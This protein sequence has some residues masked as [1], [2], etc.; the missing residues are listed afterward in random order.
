MHRIDGPGATVDNRFTDGD[1]IGGVQ[2]T[3]VTD[4][5]ANDVQENICKVIEDAGV[6]LSKGNFSQLKTAIAAMIAA[7]S[8]DLLNTVRTGVASAATVNLTTAAPNSR[9]INITGSNSISGFTIAAGKC[10]FVRFDAVLTLTNSASLVT[11]SGA[12]IVTAA[13]DTCIIRATAANVVEILCYTPGIPQ[14]IGYRQTQQNVLASRA[15]NTTYTN[16]TGRTIWVLASINVAS[17]AAPLLVLDGVSSASI[18]NNGS[19]AN[20]ILFSFPVKDGQTYRINGGTSA[21]YWS[22]MR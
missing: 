14:A 3:V 5:W 10:Y 2:A 9:H 1:P 19:G 4:D 21:G 12:D 17:G 22:E 6:T 16:N 7:G 18:G 13:G 11:Q 15:I 20:I 8:L